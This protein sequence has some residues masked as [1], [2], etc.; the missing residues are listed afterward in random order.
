LPAGA[1]VTDAQDMTEQQ[2][3]W[4]ARYSES[5]QI[6]SGNPNVAFVREVE[7]LPPGTALDLGCG[8]GADAIWLVRRG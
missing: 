6:W 8:E 7:S 2:E 1:V 5:Q 4:D 3:S